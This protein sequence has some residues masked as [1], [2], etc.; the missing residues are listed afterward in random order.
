MMSS[1]GSFKDVLEFFDR[2][3]ERLKL[4][5]YIYDILS[6][7]QRCLSVSFPVR[8]DDGSIRIFEGY[9]VHYNYALGPCKGGVRYHPSVTLDEVTALAAIMT[10]KCSLVGLPY[11]GGKGGVACNPTKMSP[12]ELERLTRRYVYM[13][14][15]L[16]G[17]EV[18][19][20][21][22][23]LYTNE[24]IMAWMMDTYSMLKGYTVPGV[25]TGKPVDIGGTLG[26][27]YAT[28]RGV[29]IVT[30]R[31][32][33]HYGIPVENATVAI[34]G[35]GNVGAYAAKDLAERGV[36]IVGITTSRGGLFN[37]DGLP[38][39]K[40]FEEV[41]VN[42]RHPSE[43]GGGDYI[44]PAEANKAILEMDVDVLI[45]AAME[46]Q[47]TR[48]NADRINAKIV[49]EG[50][51]APTTSDGDRILCERNIPVVPDVLA[52]SGGV[53]VSYFEWVQDIQS[54][55]WTEE[56]VVRRLDER[57]LDSFTRVINLAEKEKLDLRTAAYM[58]AI[59]RVAR[60][61]RMRGIFP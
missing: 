10:W 36:K 7:P 60:A 45:P 35:F 57:I 49:V 12:S 59:D 40:L 13:V 39:Q 9:R 28:G 29:A 20:M 37:S 33:E 30:V 8:M 1:D 21:A 5:R 34:Q 11:G 61:I 54:F 52:N 58:I 44:G 38:V 23:D 51:N 31:A 56:E 22:P 27:N 24:Q 15:P 42:R 26:R 2:A 16:I 48:E 4:E 25:V 43:V 19:I 46:E 6:K 18:D 55:F 41:Y 32:L 17:P 50:A 47:I 14:L 3:A 53:I